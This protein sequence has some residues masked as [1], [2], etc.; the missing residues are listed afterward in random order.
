MIWRMSNRFDPAAL[1][2]ADRH[3]N[4]QKPG[5]PQFCPPGKALVLLA[6]S[7]A[8]ALWVSSYQRY[9]KHAWPGAWVN[10]LFRNEGA[11]LSSALILQAVAATRAAWGEPNSEGMI[12]FINT[13]KVRKKRDWGRCYRKAGFNVVGRTKERNYIVLQLLPENM[14]D[15]QWAVGAQA[16]LFNMAITAKEKDNGS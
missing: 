13:E 5:T 15:A 6:N 3:Y 4:R 14:P 1:P 10:T 9:A 8:N 2:L 16:S 7:P 11:G 12:T